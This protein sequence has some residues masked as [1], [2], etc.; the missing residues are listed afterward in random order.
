MTWERNFPNGQFVREGTSETT[1]TNNRGNIVTLDPSRDIRLKDSTFYVPA[2][3]TDLVETSP[4]V[5][6]AVSVRYGIPIETGPNE[7][8][9]V[10][11]VPL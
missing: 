6:L 1:L 8:L 3:N 10:T 4:E 2:K 11:R 7:M 9:Q 5:A